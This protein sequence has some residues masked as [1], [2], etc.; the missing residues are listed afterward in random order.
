MKTKNERLASLDILRGLDL[1][2]LVFLQPV[3]VALGA[4][5]D[6]PFFNAILYQFN[7]E[8]W[9]G[10]RVWDIVMPL[11]LFMTGIAMPF[12]FNKYLTN[13]NKTALYKRIF[14]RVIILFILGMIVQGNLL[15]LDHH[16]FRFYSNTL[17]AIA[18]GYLITGVAMLHLTF[19]RQIILAVILL[20]IY[21]I[22]MTFLGDFTP[23]GNF[24]MKVDKAVL[25]RFMDGV[26]WNNDGTWAF[27]SSYNYT[28][29]WSSLTFGVTVMM[30]SFAGQ[31]IRK[32][33]DRLKNAQILLLIGVVCIAAGLLWGLQ[34]PIIKK[35]W[36]SSM[37][38]FSGGICFILISICYYLIDYKGHTKGLQFLNYYGMNSITAYV[39]GEVVNFRGIAQSVFY[40]LE[41]LL[42]NYY[43]VW[44]TFCNFLILFFI[45]KLMYK[46]KVFIK[47]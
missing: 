16:Y 19:K 21:W 23:E 36:T 1:F 2:F 32:G 11:F 43:S 33:S 5:L 45:L 31:I 7:H 24:A 38:L 9:E 14:R 13:D 29:I 25:G 26:F 30:G 15:G 4:Q 17:Q 34:M 46:H 8:V 12:S 40:G 35:L 28:W 20:L 18:V 44:I 39:L 42:D 27:S 41:P 47:I 37:T 6:L 3:I 22:P 10:F